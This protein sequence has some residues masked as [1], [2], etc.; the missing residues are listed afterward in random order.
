MKIDIKK[1]DNNKK[2][3]ISVEVPALLIESYFKTAA[4]E[5][6]KNLKVKGFRPGKAPIDIVEREIGSERLY[7][8]VT[9]IVL[10]RTLP[11]IIRDEKLEIIGQPEITVKKIAKGNS[12]EYQV[13]FHLVPEVKLGKYKGLEVKNKDLKIEKQEIDKSLNYLQNSRI[14]IIT[15]N[16]AAKKGDRVEA[17]FEIRYGSVKVEDGESKN[18]PLVLGNSKFLPG[19]EEKIEGMKVGDEKEFSLKAPDDWIDK[20][21]AGKNLDFKIKINLV[22]EREIPKIDDEFAKSLGEFKSLSELK[23]NIEEGLIKEKKQKEKERIRIELIEKVAEKSEMDIPEF[24]IDEESEKILNEFKMSTSDMG[25]EFDKYLKEIKK[26][27]DELKKEWRKQAE[28][29]VKISLCLR[30]IIEK[31]GIEVGDVEIEEKVNQDLKNYP[32]IKKAEKNIDLP[33]LKDYTKNIL[34]NEKVFNLLEEEAKLI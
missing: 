27:V 32:D 10:Q 28:K 22:Q 17:D 15:I 6:S 16:R 24:L 25:L 34:K 21:I 29:R 30:E 26:T 18:H 2:V 14:K 4:E 11:G 33:A 8:E 12:M 31:E 7:N 5:L 19:F 9:N 20:R 13:I 3:E 23:K 1:I